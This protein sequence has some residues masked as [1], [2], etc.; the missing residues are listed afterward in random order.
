MSPCGLQ[1]GEEQAEGCS[2]ALTSCERQTK[3]ATSCR[4]LHAYLL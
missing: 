2:A 4:G 1:Q 3:Y